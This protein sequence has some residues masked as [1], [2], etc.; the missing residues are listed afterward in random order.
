M[1]TVR[2]SDGVIVNAAVLTAADVVHQPVLCPA[3]GQLL[4]KWPE[5]WDAH[6]AHKCKGLSC[7]TAKNRKAEFKRAL[8][9]LFR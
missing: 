3:C 1:K 7:K 5:G 4:K 6:A 2:N 8:N 9:H